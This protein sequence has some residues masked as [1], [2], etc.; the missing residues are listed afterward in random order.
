MIHQSF[1]SRLPCNYDQPSNWNTKVGSFKTTRTCEINIMLPAFH[2][3]HII[4][5]TAYVDETNQLSSRYDMIIGRD[6]IS[7]LG[8]SF[9][10]ND[11]LME[12]D[13]AT[14]SMQNPKIFDLDSR[15]DIAKEMYMMHDPDT[16]EAKRI[17]AI[18]DAKYC[19][20][21]LEKITRECEHLNEEE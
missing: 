16:T 12:W 18:L 20:A 5:W 6:L 8:M 11:Y 17:Q 13:N 1:V 14:I 10:F 4:N 9:R 3:K 7:E 2:E 15:E 19:K 21:D